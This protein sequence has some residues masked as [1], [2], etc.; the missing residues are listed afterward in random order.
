MVSAESNV[1]KASE[2]AELSIAENL[3]YETSNSWCYGNGMGWETGGV[4]A[5]WCDKAQSFSVRCLQDVRP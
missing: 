2:M 4:A 1:V 3:N 5:I